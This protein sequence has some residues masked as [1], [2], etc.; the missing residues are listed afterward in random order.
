MNLDRDLRDAL[1]PL[2]ASDPV[3]DATRVLGVLGKTPAPGPLGLPKAAWWTGLAALALG[4]LG[5]WAIARGSAPL[6]DAPPKKEEPQKP[7]SRTEPMDVMPE[8]L[9]LMAFGTIAIDEP[10]VGPQKLEP[11]G[12][13]TKVG[14]AFETKTGMAGIYAYANDAR[15]RLATDTIATVEPQMIV[16]TKGRV[17]ICDVSRPSLVRVRADLAIVEV[18]TATAMVER[19]NTGLWVCS[20][21]GAVVVRTTAGEAVKLTAMQQ[22]E[23]DA[24]RGPGEVTKL[25][26]TG[27]V[28][29]W[30]SQM[31]LLQQDQAELHERTDYLVVSWIEGAHR[32]AASVELRRLGSHPVPRLY[33]ALGK[34]ADDPAL[35]HRTVALIGDLAQYSQ[36]DWLFVL[37][38]RDD[39]EIRGLMFRAL[40]RVTGEPVETEEFWRTAPEAER[41]AALKK[42]RDRCR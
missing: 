6:P 25:P 20:L 32:D 30:M 26:F 8:W 33:D 4:A 24:G 11:G 38:E 7:P 36:R 3:A 35:L 14:T 39:A 13:Q 1:Q 40:V 12:Y 22:V 41:E 18:D 28:T 23:I 15:V 31:I 27:T 9:N 16:L 37:L 21:E 10:D 2:D 34:A 17:W 5:G 19:T 29:G 42:W